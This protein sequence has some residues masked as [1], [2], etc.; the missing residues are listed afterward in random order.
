M[1]VTMNALKHQTYLQPELYDTGQGYAKVERGHVKLYYSYF[2]F[3]WKNRRH[4]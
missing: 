1:H 2:G 3:F 4:V